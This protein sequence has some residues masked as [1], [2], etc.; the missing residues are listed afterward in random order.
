MPNVY[1]PA[2]QVSDDYF[3]LIHTWF[4]PKWVVRAAGPQAEVAAAMRTALAS[5]DPQFPFSEFRTMDQVRSKSLG[6]P[7]LES[8][9]LAALAGLALLL[10]AVGVYG[11]I[12]QSVIERTREFGIRLALGASIRRAVASAAGPGIALTA[13]GVA[14]GCVLAR[15]AGSLLSA[16]IYKVEPTDAATFAVAAFTLLIVAALASILPS[17][18]I[19]RID[20]ALTLRDQ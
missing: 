15:L 5:V 17:L 3:Q 13:A 6:L 12:A 10:A 19:A 20:P 2:T 11:L 7:R 14:I 1:L 16:L 4:P 18:R 9:L 8:G